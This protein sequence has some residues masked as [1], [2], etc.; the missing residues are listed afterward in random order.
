VRALRSIALAAAVTAAVAAGTGTALADPPTAD[1]PPPVTSIVAVGSDTTTGLFDQFST[2][3]NAGSPAPSR[4]L[5]SWDATPPSGATTTIQS[6]GTSTTCDITRP[7]GSGAGI[8][9]LQAKLTFTSGGTTY[10]CVDIARTSRK[11]QAS[12][13]TGLATVLFAKDVVTYAYVTG[14]NAVSN[15]TNQE[16]TAIYSCNASLI[17]GETYPDAPVTWSEVGGT[18]TAAIVPVL[19]QASSGTRQ[20]F[21]TGLGLTYTTP[22]SCVVNGVSTVD[23]SVIEENEGTNSEFTTANTGVANVIVPFSAGSYIGEVY[24]K[25]NTLQ[26]P[27]NLVLGEVNGIS[28]VTTTHTDNVTAFYALLVRPLNAVVLSTGTSPYVPTYLQPLLGAS[29]NSGWICK[30]TAT[31]DITDYGFA[32]A[33]NCGSVTHQ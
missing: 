18:S 32:P 26:S 12:D 33:S 28:G 21:L 8:S 17:P 29:N 30:T 5:F 31:T 13:G 14:G 25:F 24:T 6:K 1:T 4:D 3:F 11:T 2:D 19:P 22:P 10:D 15:L 23:A 9:Q 7:N 20:S 27:G 16:L